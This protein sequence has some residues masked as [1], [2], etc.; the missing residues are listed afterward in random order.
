MHIASS[1]SRRATSDREDDMRFRFIE[2]AMVAHAAAASALVL[3]LALTLSS[4][5]AEDQT[6][7]MK[8]TLPTINDPVHQF[9]KNFATAVEKDSGGRIKAEVFPASQL[10]SIPRQI[11]GVQFG[12]IQAAVIPPEFYV[13]V[14]ERFGIMAAPGLVESQQHGQRLTADPAVL[15]LMLG[16]GADKGLHGVGLFIA[17]PSCLIARTPVRHLADLEG[18]KIRIFASDFQSVALKRL[19]ATPVAMTLGDVLPALQQGAIDGA[20]SGITVY[21]TMHYNDAAKYVT[22]I[23]QPAIFLI[24]EI[25]GKWYA[26]LPPDLQKVIDAAGA[27]ESVAI[28]PVTTEGYE[29]ARKDWVAR[30]GELIKLPPNEQ[31]EMMATLASVGEEVSKAKPLLHE[32]FEVVADAAKRTRQSPSQ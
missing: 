2:R 14:D 5:R 24:L 6:Y 25:S 3:S 1:A 7:T 27:R 8:I 20:I 22:E 23:N 16:L 9:A 4:A 31:S 18:K 26:S 30:G 21:T 32:A 15:K 19:G 29:Q 10:G 17:L 28:N 13:G 12:A 11:E